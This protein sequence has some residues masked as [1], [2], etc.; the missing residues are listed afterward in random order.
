MHHDV[1]DVAVHEHLARPLAGDLVCRH[2]AVGAADPQAGGRLDRG[3]VLEE[4]RLLRAH[5]LGPAAIGLEDLAQVRHG[6]SVSGTSG[7]ASARRASPLRRMGRRAVTRA[8][9]GAAQAFAAAVTLAF[10]FA[11]SALAAVFRSVTLRG[12]S[13]FTVAFVAPAFFVDLV[14]RAAMMPARRNSDAA[15]VDGC[16]PCRSSSSPSPRPSSRRTGAPSGRSSR[17]SR[18]TGRRAGGASPRPRSGRRDASCL[19]P[20]SFE[21]R[22]TCWELSLWVRGPHGRPGG[23]IQ[24]FGDILAHPAAQARKAARALF[25]RLHHHPRLL[26]ILEQAV[27]LGHRRAAARRDAPPPAAVEHAA[28]CRRSLSVMDSRIAS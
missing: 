8:G 18:R 23:A 9:L 14:G 22:P 3:Q 27:H 13:R 7:C 12:R 11:R 25:E 2:A 5:A 16:A 19:Q 15:C 10:F 24:G 20:A 28:A 4:R 17:G 21:S 1:R 26:E 6:S